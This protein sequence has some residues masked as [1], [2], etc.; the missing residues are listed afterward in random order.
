MLRL[1]GVLLLIAST[2]TAQSYQQPWQSQPSQP[3]QSPQ[4]PG[5]QVQQTPQQQAEQKRQE[6]ISRCSMETDDTTRTMCMSGC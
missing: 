3:V 1:I 6:C 2:A 5:D 4:T